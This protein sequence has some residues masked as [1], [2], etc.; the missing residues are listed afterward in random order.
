VSRTLNH[1]IVEWTLSS[2]SYAV[3]DHRVQGLGLEP[4]GMTYHAGGHL[5]VGGDIGEV[6]KNLDIFGVCKH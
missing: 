6:S 5:G 1:T 4:E 2:D 3:F